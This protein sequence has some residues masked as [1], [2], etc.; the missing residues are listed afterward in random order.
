[1]EKIQ[2][3]DASIA[4]EIRKGMKLASSEDKG[5]MSKNSFTEYATLADANL[6]NKSGIYQCSGKN[7]PSGYTAYIVLAI[8]FDAFVK[9]IA[10]PNPSV[11]ID[12]TL[13]N[14]MYIRYSIPKGWSSW[15][16]VSFT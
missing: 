9:Q 14:K 8:A 12:D 10:F 7:I 4:E 11:T 16:S 13:Y 5:L 2:I 6:A 1:M 3:S 15:K